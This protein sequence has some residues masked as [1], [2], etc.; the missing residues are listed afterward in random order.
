MT[1]RDRRAVV[2]GGAIVLGAWL[3]VWGVPRLGAEWR[4]NRE[5]VEAQRLLLAETRR[6]IDALPRMEDSAH[7]L[8][9]RV[10]GLAP[11]ILSGASSA[12]ALSDLSG[13]MN[14]IVGLAH[15]RMLR[16]EAA[17]D[18][19]AAGPLRRV[20]A[21]V[22]IETDFRGVAELL[23]YLGQ[24]QLVAVAERLQ[25]TAADPG[26]VPATLEQLNLV[27]WVSAWYLARES[28]G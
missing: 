7:V 11:R 6:A 5:R 9:G 16:F 25:V 4:E 2:I 15:G 26:A 17:P 19:A 10:A 1:P 24:G 22:E 13:R 12:V 21:Q 8:T 28:A 27:L 14:T 20:T 23:D 3:L 18:S